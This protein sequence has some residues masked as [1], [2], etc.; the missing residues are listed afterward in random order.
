MKDGR[1]RKVGTYAELMANDVEFRTLINSHVAS[2][3]EDE[4]IELEQASPA[5]DS[6]LNQL[7]TQDRNEISVRVD[8]REINEA[9]VT[10]L[11]ERN[12]LSVIQGGLAN[13]DVAAAI[14]RNQATVH[15][16][17]DKEDGGVKKGTL[18][19]EDVSASKMGFRDVVLY[20]AAGP[21]T[22]MTLMTFGYFFLVHCV[23]LIS[24]FWLSFWI[25]DKLGFGTNHG[26][27]SIYLG[28]YGAFTVIFTIGVLTRGL[29]FAYIT[30]KKAHILHDD[31]FDSIMRAPMAFFD[32]TPLGRILSAFSKHQLH[33]DDTMPDALMQSLQYAPLALGALLLVA[34]AVHWSNT[35]AT[36]VLVAMGLSLCYFTAPAETKLKQMEAVSKPP[37][38]AHLTASLEGLFS[39]RAYHAQARFDKINLDLLDRNHQSLYALQTMKTWIAF[40]LDMLSSF[41]VFFTALFLVIFSDRS[42]PAQATSNAGLALSNALQMLVFL[43]WTVRMLGDVQGQMGSVGQLVF[44][45]HEI[46]SEA[47]AE[48]PNAKPPVGWPSQGEVE[49]QNVV[50][51]YHKFGV[52]VLKNVSFAIRPSEK[53]GIVGRTGSGKS[54]LLISLLR[55]VEAAEGRVLVDGVDISKIGLRDLRTKVAIIPQEPVLFVGTIRTN[56][57]PFNRCPDEEIWRALHAVHLAGKIRAMP[58]QLE[59]EVVENGKNFSVGQRQL[60]CIARAVLSQAKVLVLD[61]ATAAIDMA[62]DLL[63]QTAIKANFSEMTVLTI[64]H[65]LNTIIESDRV[66]VMD[67]GKV[68]EFDEPITLLNK[69]NGDF[70]ALVAQTGPATATKLREIAQLASHTRHAK[71][72]STIPPRPYLCRAQP[73]IPLI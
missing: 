64:A 6:M 4:E 24:D 19:T 1:M 53:I 62:T 55:I 10:S 26:G 27:D 51:R 22:T 48:I 34:T 43:Q 44:Y 54:T 46:P 29:A 72:C 58:R 59:S 31:M 39:I 15:S 7:S 73:H 33:V 71:D 23:R 66:L 45:G 8:N 60:F 50:L 61:E 16:M 37:I 56:L 42:N 36:V 17:V 11:I 69:P 32:T 30:A 47:P 13:H 18:V 12:Q 38:Y 21:G 52:N 5:T 67:G 20:L 41:V 40:Y 28:S 49:F 65:R 2:T 25:P 63:I 14:L 57:D 9:T 68:M 70:A 35:V 3:E